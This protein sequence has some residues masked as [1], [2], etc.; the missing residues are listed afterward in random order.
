MRNQCAKTS[1]KRFW[2]HAFSDTPYSFHRTE[3][4]PAA[5]SHSRSCKSSINLLIIYK[6]HFLEAFAA[7]SPCITRHL[8]GEDF[9]VHALA[10][11]GQSW[12]NTCTPKNAIHPVRTTQFV[13]VPSGGVR[14][15][16]GPNWMISLDFST[17]VI[18]FFA[19]QLTPD[20]FFIR[21]VATRIHHKKV[22]DPNL[23]GFYSLRFILLF[24][25]I[26][27]CAK[28]VLHSP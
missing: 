1:R 5:S 2:I 14:L 7:G 28:R 12:V 18:F 19:G 26:G 3:P 27:W 17:G 25:G 8:I 10:T 21:G 20:R 22:R 13:F 15:S 9:T 16:P 24:T 11:V 23:C 4:P 6:A